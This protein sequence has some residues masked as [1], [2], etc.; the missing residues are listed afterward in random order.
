MAFSQFDRDDVFRSIEIRSFPVEGGSSR[1]LPAMSE[2]KEFVR[3]R[4]FV[5]VPLIRVDN[6]NRAFSIG[7][8]SRSISR[9]SPFSVKF[10]HALRDP[11]TNVRV[12][13]RVRF[14]F[15]L[16]IFSDVKS[17][18]LTEIPDLRNCHQLRVL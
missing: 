8:A 6:R 9:S 11:D 16:S 15:Q 2:I 3:V 4:L 12:S 7:P 17:N 14:I 18:Y 5:K 1:S 13:V 10:I